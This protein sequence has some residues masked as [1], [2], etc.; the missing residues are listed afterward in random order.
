MKWRG[1]FRWIVIILAEDCLGFGAAEPV[2]ESRCSFGVRRIFKDRRVVDERLR[3]IRFSAKSKR[4]VRMLRAHVLAAEIDFRRQRHVRQIERAR[5]DLVSG[6]GVQ[7]A[8]LQAR[9]DGWLGEYLL[10]I[11]GGAKNFLHQIG[12]L[13]RLGGKHDGEDN[14][15]ALRVGDGIGAAKAQAGPQQDLPHIFFA[16]GGSVKAGSESAFGAVSNHHLRMRDGLRGTSLAGA[17]HG[18]HRAG[19]DRDK[20]VGANAAAGDQL[21]QRARSLGAT[22]E[23]ELE[24]LRRCGFQRA[25]HH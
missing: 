17:Q 15:A 21:R 10:L 16:F 8:A 14:V 12:L 4:H 23:F 9:H 20:N 11:D 6:R 1:I 24:S 25:F 3:S 2:D 18:E 19:S 5:L 7:F 13:V 22:V